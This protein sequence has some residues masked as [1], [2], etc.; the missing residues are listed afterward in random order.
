MDEVIKLTVTSE[1]R[2][3][4]QSISYSKGNLVTKNCLVVQALKEK[5]PSIKGITCFTNGAVVDGYNFRLN[6]SAI[7]ITRKSW[8]QWDELNLPIDI[9]LTKF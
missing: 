1:H 2:K 6:E 3:K 7:S 9:E 4:A 5:F 8:E